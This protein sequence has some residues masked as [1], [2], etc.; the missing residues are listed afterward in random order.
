M[1][2]SH[3]ESDEVHSGTDAPDADDPIGVARPERPT[4]ATRIDREVEA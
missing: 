2:P 4:T 3:E 1:Y